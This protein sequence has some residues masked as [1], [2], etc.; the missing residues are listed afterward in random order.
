M[1]PLSSCALRLDMSGSLPAS[2]FQLCQSAVQCSVA[3]R[4]PGDQTGPIRTSPHADQFG[5]VLPGETKTL[6]YRDIADIEVD[7]YTHKIE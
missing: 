2:M 3:A 6:H 1:Y 5:P 4:G 7:K